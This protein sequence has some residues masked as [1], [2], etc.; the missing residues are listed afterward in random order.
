MTVGDTA[1][2]GQKLGFPAPGS[3]V[4][5]APPALKRALVPADGVP[6]VSR[7]VHGD[8]A[9]NGRVEPAPPRAANVSGSPLIAA[10]A[11]LGIAV[12]LELAGLSS[13]A[14]RRR[15]GTRRTC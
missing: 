11:M 5:G 14:R 2:D 15:A 8:L 4:P 13:T 9:K 7:T 3:A 12:G 6:L 1:A 10:A